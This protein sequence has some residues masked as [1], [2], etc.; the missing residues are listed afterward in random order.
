MSDVELGLESRAA[1][2]SEKSSYRFFGGA[3]SLRDGLSLGEG[4]VRDTPWRAGSETV[5]DAAAAGDAR[6]RRR[7]F[8]SA[9]VESGSQEVSWAAGS[10]SSRIHGA[11]RIKH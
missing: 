8:R 9:P 10:T 2:R 6:Q 5:V 4:R 7:S 3:E 11:A 1:G